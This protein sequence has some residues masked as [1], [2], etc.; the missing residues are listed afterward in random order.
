[1]AM[2]ATLRKSGV[3]GAQKRKIYDVTFDA[4]TGTFKSGLD[5]VESCV[6]NGANGDEAVV[7]NSNDGTLGSVNGDLYFSSVGIT[8]AA[9]VTIDGI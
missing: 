3:I 9:V 7:I 5:K 8:E 4:T 2:T 6:I 1:M